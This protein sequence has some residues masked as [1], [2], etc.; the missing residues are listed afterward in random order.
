LKRPN[1]DV[2]TDIR[3]ISRQSCPICKVEKFLARAEAGGPRI[4]VRCPSIG[5]PH[6]DRLPARG[7]KVCAVVHVLPPAICD[8]VPRPS[9]GT[10]GSSCRSAQPVRP[11]R[12]KRTA[13]LHCDRFC[14][15]EFREA[16]RLRGTGVQK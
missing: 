15:P 6:R 3:A 5:P 4:R 1:R 10:T 9:R 7:F 12:Q 11:G 8:C 13:L 16:R 14:R 2:V